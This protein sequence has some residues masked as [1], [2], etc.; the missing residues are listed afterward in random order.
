MNKEKKELAVIAAGVIILLIVFIG[1]M[2][3]KS[4]RKTGGTGKTSGRADSV[5]PGGN[6]PAKPAYFN[7]K[8]LQAQTER[9]RTPWGR[10]PFV[11]ELDRAANISELRLQGISYGT[12][13]AGFAFINDEIVK[14]GGKIGDYEVS[15]VLK[16]RVLVK[17]GAQSFYL[18]FAEE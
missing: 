15:E 9:A 13:R 7:E 2:K 18:T 8:D 14:K 4:A 5:R 16:D 10:D 12:D 11:A 6:A 3:G 17:K 1:N